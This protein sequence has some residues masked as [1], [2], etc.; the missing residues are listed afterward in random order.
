M[1]QGSYLFIFSFN[2]YIY[3]GHFSMLGPMLEGRGPELNKTE[4]ASALLGFAL[5]GKVG[6]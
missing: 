6:H 4:M 5:C 3:I 2:K 1:A